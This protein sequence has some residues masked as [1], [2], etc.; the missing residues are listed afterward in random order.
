MVDINLGSLNLCSDKYFDVNNYLRNSVDLELE[1]SGQY[2]CVASSRSGKY[3]WKSQLSV[4]PPSASNKAL[5]SNGFDPVRRPPPPHQPYV[6]KVDS[7]SITIAW[8]PTQYQSHSLPAEMEFNSV[9]KT[10]LIFEPKKE[11][12]EDFITTDKKGSVEPSYIDD[13]YYDSGEADNSARRNRR[14]PSSGSSA[15]FGPSETDAFFK[16]LEKPH[17]FSSGKFLET[18]SSQEQESSI[19]FGDVVSQII[20]NKEKLEA[21]GNTEEEYEYTDG[22]DYDEDGQD[23]RNSAGE[24]NESTNLVLTTSSTTTST[25]STTTTTPTPTTSTGKPIT[26]SLVNPK[27]YVNLH[28]FK[29]DPPMT[30]KVYIH[31]KNRLLN[32]RNIM[33]QTSTYFFQVEYYSPDETKSEWLLGATAVSEQTFTLQVCTIIYTNWFHPKNI[34]RHLL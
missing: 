1:D 29:P 8:N 26:S 13:D 10:P 25:T 31:T 6:I 3:V 7:S 20:T 30:Y 19:G 24:D 9:P 27:E 2:E 18:E 12:R 28:H 15:E 22:D 32:L 5:S 16:A 17:R 23:S 14:S 4:V 21:E 33:F 11:P 34:S